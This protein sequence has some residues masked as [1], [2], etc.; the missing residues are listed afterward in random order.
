MSLP[1]TERSSANLDDTLWKNRAGMK[2]A[3]G[4]AQNGAQQVERALVKMLS[5]R[6]SINKYIS[7]NYDIVTSTKISFY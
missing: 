3:N 6:L 5:K 2:S 7:Q 4:N 1:P